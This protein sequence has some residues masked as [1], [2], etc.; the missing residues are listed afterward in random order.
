LRRLAL[1]LLIYALVLFALGA[2]PAMALDRNAFSFTRYDL[3]ITVDPHQHGLAAEGTVEVRNVSQGPQREVSLQISSSLRWLSVRADGAEVEWL[4]QSY[5]SDIDHTGLLSEA[6]V[7]LD[8]PVA[9]GQTLLL[10][11]RYSGTVQKDTTRLERIGT[12]EDV[13]L[14]SDWDEISDN[15]TALRGAGFVVWYP[16]SMEA[17]NLSQGNELFEIM[18]AWRERET[19][20][21]LGVQLSRAAAPG[22]DQ[23]KFIFVVNSSPSAAGPAISAEFRGVDPVIV[24]LGDPAETADRPRVAAYYTAAHTDYARDYMAAA[25]TVIPSLEE[26]FGAPRRKVVLVELTDPNALP[27]DAG[28]YYF[29][30][31]RN[32][33]PAVAEV[34]LA[35]PVVH[36]ILESPRP[37]IREGL[38]V[39]AQALIRERQAGR[40]AALAY[41]GQFSPVLAVAEAESHGSLPPG[42]NS[43]AAP[44]SGLQPLVTTADE[45]FFRT[46]A[47][48]VWWMLRDMVG[49]RVLQSALAQYHGADDRDSGYMQRLIEKQDLPKRDL[50]AFFDDWVYRDRGLPQLRIN[51]ANARR[52]LGVQTVTAVTIENFGEAWCEVPVTVRSRDGENKARVVVPGKGKATVRVALEAAP[53]EAEVN[54]GSVPEAERGNNVIPVT[55]T[56]SAER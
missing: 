54:D 41:L 1:A 40:R 46:K 8:K 16:V 10:N 21:V 13:A 5:T 42:E 43:A 25:E 9:P 38:A 24:L 29:V 50:E 14:R 12:P 39:F 7:K 4:E 20:A 47:G 23:S 11:L 33:P 32:L 44:G 37:W 35:R 17:A 22:G 27:Y 52:T 53:S 56:P 15:F 30:P 55:V 48:Y 49:D 18:R 45:V 51:S 19:S 34:A 31:M 3:R 6:I 36:A 26:W 2:L 28:A